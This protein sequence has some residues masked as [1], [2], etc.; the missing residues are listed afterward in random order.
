M[1]A[2]MLHQVTL[3]TLVVAACA[4]LAC[5]AGALTVGRARGA[6]LVG[7]PLDLAIPVRLDRTDDEPCASAD[8]FYGEQKL[9]GAPSV[10]WQP[11]ASGE[12]VVHVTSAVPVDEPMITVYLRVGCGEP[13]TRRFVMLAELPPDSEPAMPL[14]ARRP[15]P[16]QAPRV[17]SPAA[18]AA[19]AAAART[20]AAAT[21]TAPVD[22]RGPR[23]RVPLPAEAAVAALRAERSLPAARPSAAAPLPRARKPGGGAAGSRLKLEPIELGPERDPVL[24]L[25]TQLGGEPA[26]DPL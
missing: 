2:F 20:P 19:A 3:R 26:T 18:A 22:A 16:E 21:S 15:A 6:V 1:G 7:R 17:Q 23:R 5:D 25:S 13:T 14:V 8:V 12:G 10:R 11:G 4:W 24:R 9:P